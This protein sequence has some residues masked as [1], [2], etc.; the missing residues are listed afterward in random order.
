MYGVGGWGLVTESV[1]LKGMI[2]GLM[3][4]APVKDMSGNSMTMALSLLMPLSPGKIA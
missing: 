1:G 4:P 2:K 3:Q